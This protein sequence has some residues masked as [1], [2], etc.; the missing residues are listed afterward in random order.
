MEFPVMV[1][2]TFG[3]ERELL[4]PSAVGFGKERWGDLK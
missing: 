4:V 1:K 2:D 3:I